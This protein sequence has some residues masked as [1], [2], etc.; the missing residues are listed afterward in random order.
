M[1][2]DKKAEMTKVLKNR[3]LYF[4]TLETQN[5]AKK[6]VYWEELQSTTI[7][8]TRTANQVILNEF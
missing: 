6:E 1:K 2:Q 3:K 7:Y 5:I 4:F 8:I